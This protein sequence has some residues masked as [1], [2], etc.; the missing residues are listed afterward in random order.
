MVQRPEIRLSSWRSA[1]SFTELAVGLTE[2]SGLRCCAPAGGATARIVRNSKAATTKRMR[3][4]SIAMIVTPIIKGVI[5]RAADDPVIL[6]DDVG[7]QG[8]S[9]PN[10]W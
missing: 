6:V 1:S 4:T 3:A 10:P 5:I 9:W 2:L 8:V 7:H